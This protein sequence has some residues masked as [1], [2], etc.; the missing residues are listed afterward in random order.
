MD[1]SEDM[2]AKLNA[3]GE[4]LKKSI[5]PFGK[6]G[7]MTAYQAARACW[8]A[9]T[10]LAERDATIERLT[11]GVEDLTA[12]NMR[13]CDHVANW[14]CEAKTEAARATTAERER[15][16]ARAEVERLRDVLDHANELLVDTWNDAMYGD[17]EDE[18]VVREARAALQQSEEPK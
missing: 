14:R 15:D 11:K 16:E 2:V 7:D 1:G 6:P 10:A 17:P 5:S 13:L 4:I 9:A 18:I 12:A 8:E 3:A